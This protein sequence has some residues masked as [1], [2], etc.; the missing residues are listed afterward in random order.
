MN[1]VILIW[2]ADTAVVASAACRKLR[3]NL[4]VSEWRQY[5]GADVP[6]EKTCKELPPGDPE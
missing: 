5:V 1:G 3:R 2:T 6:Y 4:K